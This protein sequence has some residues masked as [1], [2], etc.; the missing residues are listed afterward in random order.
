MENNTLCLSVKD[1]G[2][3]DLVVVGGGCTGTFAA[4]R[5]ARLGLKVALIEK[6]NCF[7]GVATSGLVNIWHSLFDFDGKAQIIHGLTEEVQ[8][9]LL[10]RG[11]AMLINSAS[12]GISFDPN[13][14][15]RALD[16]LVENSGVKVF[17]HTHY[18]SLILNGG[19]IQKIVVANKD[20]IGTVSGGFFIDATGDGDLCRDSGVEGYMSSALQPP[21][22]CCLIKGS[23]EGKIGRLIK[24]H[25][26]EFG[27][28]DDF[29]WG[30]GVAGL[31]DVE[32]RADLHIFGKNC[33][34]AQHLSQA[35]IEGRKKL[36]ALDRL[37]KKYCDTYQGTVA[38]CSSLGIRETVHYKTRFKALEQELLIGKKYENTVMRGSY[39]VDIHD[40]LGGITFRYLNGREEYIKGKYTPAIVSDWRQRVGAFGDYAKHY[41]VPFE[42]LVQE[43]VQN[44]IP[45]GRMLNADEGAFG[46]LRV[47]VNLNQLGEAAGVAAYLALNKNRTIQEID[48][49]AVKQLLEV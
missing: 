25:G 46:A 8:A 5:A 15:K 48:G 47:M 45:V 21:T 28:I 35:E 7:G 34:D 12:A 31:D 36:Y 13:A 37:L 10:A 1:H 16:E 30:V 44:L 6:T 40:D 2:Y 27:L 49:K 22:P 29:G 38:V 41:E 39:R 26:A 33:A 4:V 42:I 19:S 3:F 32:L 18:G 17:L 43:R 9:T 14:M 11:E 23:I 20:G 24:E